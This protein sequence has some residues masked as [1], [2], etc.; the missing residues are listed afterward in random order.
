MAALTP[1]QY[2]EAISAPRIDPT[3]LG[4]KVMLSKAGESGGESDAE[5]E[6]KI[7]GSDEPPSKGKG[8]K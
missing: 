2:L 3:A 8:K 5:V 4:S 7:E 6:V 1:S